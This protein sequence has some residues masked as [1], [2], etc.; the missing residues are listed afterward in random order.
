MAGGRQRWLAGDRGLRGTVT[1]HMCSILLGRLL[2]KREREFLLS[3]RSQTTLTE[4]QAAKLNEIWDRLG[5]P[6]PVQRAW[7]EGRTDA[8]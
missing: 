2:P 6:R 4:W 5:M 1:G 8:I 7:G 3:L